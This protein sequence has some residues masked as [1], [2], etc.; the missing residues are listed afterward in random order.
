MPYH[1]ISHPL[2]RVSFPK[3]WRRVRKHVNIMHI[4]KENFLGWETS[5]PGVMVFKV[6]SPKLQNFSPLCVCSDKIMWSYTLYSE[7]SCLIQCME[8]AG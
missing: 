5:F 3:K 7:A 6:V 1:H 8:Q 2:Q 4:A